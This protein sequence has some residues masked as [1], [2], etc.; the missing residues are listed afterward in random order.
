MIREQWQINVVVYQ[1]DRSYA[2]SLLIQV[3]SGLAGV[4]LSGN[5]NSATEVSQES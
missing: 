5:S 2:H 3:N 4:A 1:D